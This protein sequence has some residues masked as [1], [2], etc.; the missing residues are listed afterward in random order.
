[1]SLHLPGRFQMT[2]LPT[3]SIERITAF[4]KEGHKES[5]TLNDVMSLA[6]LM[7]SSFG[8]VLQAR[9]QKIYEEFQAIAEA[10]CRMKADIGRLQADD[11]R[12]NKIPDAGQE[13]DAIVEATEEATNTIMEATE[14]LMAVDPSDASALSEAVNSATMTI[15]EACSFQDITGQRIAKV[16]ET[17]S[18]IE[19]RVQRFADTFG[20]EDT[21]GYLTEEEEARAKRKDELILHGP[22]MAEDAIGQDAVDA[23][24]A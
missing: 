4:L 24:F 6:D 22:Q 7:A 5:V 17:L 20:V 19:T 1:M 14:S 15:F 10:I 11:L 18:M 2:H 13:L 23:L 9:D 8:H 3:E 21:E 12:N 16:V